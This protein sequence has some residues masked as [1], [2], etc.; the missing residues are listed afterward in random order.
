[1]YIGYSFKSF[2]TY[3]YVP[4]FFM[5]IFCA[6][7]SLCSWPDKA[8]PGEQLIPPTTPIRKSSSTPALSSFQRKTTL[9]SKFSDSSSSSSV[10]VTINAENPQKEEVEVTIDNKTQKKSLCSKLS[11]Y[12][13]TLLAGFSLAAFIGYTYPLSQNALQTVN[14][15]VGQVNDDKNIFVN[16]I[17][18]IK[19]LVDTVEKA[20]ILSAL[21]A[22][23]ELA[24]AQQTNI[25]SLQ[26]LNVLKNQTAPCPSLS[27]QVLDQAARQHQQQ[28]DLYQKQ[29]VLYQQLLN[30]TN[31]NNK[32]IPTY[33]AQVLDDASRQHQQ[34]LVASESIVKNQTTPSSSSSSSSQV[35][36]RI[37][38]QPQKTKNITTIAKP[39]SNKLNNKQ[40][41]YRGSPMP[42]KGFK[43]GR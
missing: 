40:P 35:L 9:S 29:L 30:R 21:V 36:Y 6:Q 20:T 5:L 41:F 8:D 39:V 42:K 23:S 22:M 14:G 24:V 32:V 27:P 12:Y 1:M 18:E 38:K 7:S 13:C 3:M 26:L 19:P 15:Y 16:K 37:F 33:S 43:R 11:R 28:L 25:V 10:A 34:Q 2:Y 31:N 17:D 4:A